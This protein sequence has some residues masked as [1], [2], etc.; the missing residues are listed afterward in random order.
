LQEQREWPLRDYFRG[1]GEANDGRGLYCEKSWRENIAFMEADDDI[2]YSLIALDIVER[3]GDR[4]EHSPAP[5]RR[6]ERSV[7]APTQQSPPRVD[8]RADPR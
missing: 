7:H 2:H 4:F 3:F 5:A 6:R 8:R 1:S